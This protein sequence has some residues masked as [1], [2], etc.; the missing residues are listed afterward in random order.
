MP[1]HTHTHPHTHTHTHNQTQSHSHTPQT[2]RDSRGCLKQ[3]ACKEGF[4]LV[5][6]LELDLPSLTFSSFRAGSGDEFLQYEILRHNELMQKYIEEGNAELAGE[7][8]R[9]M[10]RLQTCVK[11]RDRETK[12]QQASQ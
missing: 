2:R 1:T 5:R 12:L 11:Q 10:A 7:H 3:H 8:A 4:G 6:K 9:E